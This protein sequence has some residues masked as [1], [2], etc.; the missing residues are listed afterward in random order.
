MTVREFRLS[1]PGSGLG[2]SCDANG[3]FVGSVALLRRSDA[4]GKERWEP[5][6]SRP[7]SSQVASELGLPIDF[8]SKADG[9]KAIANALNEGNV[10]RAQIATVLLAIPDPSRISNGE[11]SYE[12]MIKFVRDLHW[13]GLIKW[14]PDQHPRWPAGS[15]D[16]EGGQFAPK[17]E[18][19]TAQDQARD[20]VVGAD[21]TNAFLQYGEQ[22]GKL[23]G[24][25]YHPDSDP[26]SLDPTA[27]S[28]E[29]LRQNL[30]LHEAEVDRQV[31]W[32]TKVGRGNLKVTKNVTFISDNGIYVRVDYVVSM[33]L[34]DGFGWTL[35]PWYAAD[36]KTGRGGLT[37]NQM[38]VYPNIG[39]KTWVTPVGKNAGGAGFTIGERVYFPIVYGAQLRR[40][41]I[42]RLA[43]RRDKS[44]GNFGCHVGCDRIEF[45]R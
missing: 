22:E 10:A 43:S 42:E 18:E 13:S 21:A 40:P 5:R 41:N 44:H 24:G 9:L 12:A 8:S 33:W 23:D 16:S 29:Q 7:L 4:R 34:P 36:V 6:D 2:I 26:A 11:R 27:S 3:V 17:S 45:S 28:P 31:A 35:E 37:E 25:V 14:D 20:R 39:S 19:V 30:L 38:Q 15:P 32:L 1:P